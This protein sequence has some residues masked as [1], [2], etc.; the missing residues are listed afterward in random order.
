MSGY[1]LIPDEVRDEVLKR[2]DIVDIVGQY[3]HLSKHG[4]YLKGLCPFHSEKTPSF[5]VTPEKQIFHCYGCGKSGTVIQF[6]MGIEGYSYP[7]AMKHLAELSHIPITWGTGTV[8]ERNPHNEAKDSLIK[9][10]ELAAKLYHYILMNTSHG[11]EALLYLRGRGINDK[12]IEQFQI[13]YAPPQWDTLVQLLEKREFD[14]SLMEKGGLVSARHNGSGYV[15]RFRDRI[16]F[17][18]WDRN[19]HAVAFAGRI[20]GDGQPK[21]LNSPETMLFNKSKLLY[22]MHQA[23]THI[24][25]TGQ[26][27]LF[28]GYADVIQAW[29]AEVCNGIATMGTA[30]TGDQ[31]TLMKRMADSVTLCY[32]GDDA[33][34]AAALKA[35]PLFEEAGMHVA[36][37]MLPDRMDPDDY[38]KTHGAER[39]RHAIIA[40]AITPTKFKLISLRRN[41]ILLEDDGKRRFKDEAMDV[42]ARV[43][44]PV[45]REM[46]LKELA[47]QLD[48]PGESALVSLKQEC[49]NI[50]QKLQ[51]KNGHG[52]NHD[53]WWNNVRNDNRSIA[54][55]T[56][57]PAYVYAERS[58]L[59]LMFQDVEVSNYVER[60][61][62]EQFNVDDHAALA[63]YLYAYYAQGKEPDFSRYLAT[64][65]DDRLEKAAASISMAEV[66]LRYDT[67]LLD[68]YIDQILKVPRQREIERKK[69]EMVQ[70]ERSGQ[71]LRAAQIAQEIIALEQ[72]LKR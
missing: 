20:M 9:A 7:E 40:A 1:G 39:F 31:V 12:L 33:G 53:N 34:Q 59:A 56:L 41:H 4:K 37:A 35:I 69:E 13:G 50:R 19:G 22:N 70:A 23:R 14:L 66:S 29:D 67:E 63:A 46:H 44:S 32:D 71:V 54:P 5:T 68:D 49:A 72:E 45:E 57:R 24:K 64:L 17:P 61:L 48:L 25:R 15:D 36:V 28:E 2:N 30:L 43:A 10:H 52:D 3:V 65:Q 55:P 38:L 47:L 16:M 62:G 27:I 6:M 51:K 21:Y 8:T 58:L 60:N 26:I 42:I 18:I 11:Q